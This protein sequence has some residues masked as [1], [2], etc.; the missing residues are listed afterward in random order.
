MYTVISRL[1]ALCFTVLIG[2][3]LASAVNGSLAPIL[4]A[5]WTTLQVDNKADGSIAIQ[6]DTVVMKRGAQGGTWYF[7][8]AYRDI[9]VKAGAQYLF[10]FTAKV[11][12][13]GIANAFF[14]MA[15]ADGK[16]DEKINRVYSEQKKSGNFSTIRTVITMPPDR[17]KLRMCLSASGANTTALFKDVA[18]GELSDVKMEIAPGTGEIT[19]D[20]AIDDPLWSSALKLS[21]FRVLGLPEKTAQNQTTCR[22]A[23]K[24]GMLYI[25]CRVIEPDMG[26]VKAVTKSNSIDVYQD[27]CIEVFISPDRLSYAHI[28]LNTRGMRYWEHKYIGSR[29]TWFPAVTTTAF[30]GD[31]DA[32][33]ALGNGEWTC[34][35]RIRLKDIYGVEPAGVTPLYVNIGRHRPHG[36][37]AY[38]TFTPL[39]GKSFHVPKDFSS[40]I[41]KLDGGTDTTIPRVD[42]A[43]TKLLPEPDIPIAGKP[44]SLVL[45]SERCV[46]PSS[47]RIS[48]KNVTMDVGVRTY[49]TQTLTGTAGGTLEVILEQN[50]PFTGMTLSS[51]NRE[52]LK[53]P[54]AF[55][56]DITKNRITITGRSYDAVARGIATLS[57]IAL[58]ARFLPD[59][60]LPAMS[61]CDA[62]R[63][64]FRSWL[65][66]A[67]ETMNDTK[68]MIDAA[69]LL[70]YNKIFIML[71]SFTPRET[72]FP[73]SCAD[74]GTKNFTKEDWVDAFNYARARGLEPIPYLASWGRTQYITRKPEY[75]H[76]NVTDRSLMPQQ[77][78]YRNLDVANPE[79][80]KLMLSLQEELIDT[81][82]PRG[83]NIAFD[84]IHYGELAKSKLALDK[85]WKDSD[86][87]IAAL[88]ANAAFFD[89]KGVELYLWGDNFDP[90]QN[91]GHI[92]ISGPEMLAKVPKNMIFMDWKYEGKFDYAEE[93]PSFRMFKDA[94]FRTLGCPWYK[95]L[96]VARWV[97]TVYAG[98][99]D[100]VCLT[101]W[102]ATELHRI[103][104]EMARAAALC[105][106][107]SWSPEN[108]NLDDFPFVPDTLLQTM[109]WR[110]NSLG[111]ARKV[112]HIAAPAECTPEPAV[113][114]LLG[115]PKEY[116]LDFLR[117]NFKNYRGVD[118]SVFT[119]NGRPAAITATGSGGP[120]QINNGD[121]S[122]GL[123]AWGSQGNADEARYSITGGAL[124]SERLKPG[125]FI[126]VWQDVRLEKGKSYVLSMRVRTAAGAKAH[127]WLYPGDAQMKWDENGVTHLPS[128]SSD[129]WTKNEFPITFTGAESVRI[130]LTPEG[131]GEVW[132]DDVALRD[133]NT[134]V[135]VAEK[136]PNVRLAIGGSARAV[137]F[138]HSVNAQHISETTSMGDIGKLY[139]SIIPGVYIVR[140]EDDTAAQIPLAFR[141]NI[142]DINDY[143]LGRSMDAG[144]F[145]TVGNKHFINLPTFTW[146]N[147]YPGKRIKEIEVVPGNS[148]NMTL[149]VFGV[150]LD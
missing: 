129:G 51:K 3:S 150:S 85:G 33:T 5:D 127:V 1:T 69:W 72:P 103:R 29:A 149:L 36:D 100:G 92:D 118:F 81:L 143:A 115:F 80:V 14:Y 86:W 17:T 55:R 67:G 46:L 58:R 48:E 8:R 26:A 107:L 136:H 82:K 110:T 34:E 97:N 15:G 30:T 70:R 139:E 104:P 63:I 73:F 74:I 53:S 105:G 21:A 109:A 145:G 114:A 101:S 75:K 122:L 124:C 147:P 24:D 128:F 61:L 134:A 88:T 137:T 121:F 94:G 12:G 144:L 42:L 60:S 117:T 83:F 148:R 43:F 99:G 141:V 126:R 40:I 6:G 96:N 57:L 120:G 23:V 78:Y 22:M 41:L 146:V 32:K 135:A 9:E 112:S 62:P 66:H 56:L 68:R 49:L 28:L 35:F 89:K 44:V 50:D 20:G 116:S 108:C 31:W 93:F 13:P 91:G 131:T 25:A 38:T 90:G 45:K 111:A 119:R 39:S 123:S 132:F 59:V 64:A 4:P 133:V 19:L 10:T 47:V 16:W 76:L 37:E 113:A 7:Q 102:S 84:E 18:F 140:Y 27:D 71:D 98:K 52:R 2:A 95:P 65:V 130:C 125:A 106:Y 11:D 142:G 87:I 77:S 54:E 79:A 138:L